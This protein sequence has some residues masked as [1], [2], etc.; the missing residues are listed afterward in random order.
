MGFGNPEDR[1]DRIADEL[2]EGAAEADDGLAQNSQGA[3]Q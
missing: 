2:L 3:R 1:Q